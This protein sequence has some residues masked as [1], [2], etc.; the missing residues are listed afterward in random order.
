ML[1]YPSM[2]DQL[3][4]FAAG[5]PFAVDIHTIA[6][7]RCF[8]RLHY[9]KS[10]QQ[11]IQKRLHSASHH[12]SNPTEHCLSADDNP[13]Q[14]VSC[15]VLSGEIMQVYYYPRSPKATAE[16]SVRQN[17]GSLGAHLRR[18]GES[19]AEDLSA[20]TANSSS[21]L[22]IKAAETVTVTS[23]AVVTATSSSQ[24]VSLG[25]PVAFSIAT[26]PKTELAA[27]A[28][29]ADVNISTISLETADST[30]RSSSLRTHTRAT[31]QTVF[32]SFPSPSWSSAA[33]STSGYQP[34]PDT[35]SYYHCGYAQAQFVFNGCCRIDPCRLNGYCPRWA[36]AVAAGEPNTYKAL[37]INGEYTGERTQAV[38][39]SYHVIPGST[40]VA[41]MFTIN[42]PFPATASPYTETR[43]TA[44]TATAGTT[45][46]TA[47]A[48]K[49]GLSGGVAAGI[50]VGVIAG[51]L[52]LVGAGLLWWWR[53][54]RA[55]K[56]KAV[57]T[58]AAS[59]SQFDPGPVD[60]SMAN[61]QYRAYNALPQG[62]LFPYTQSYDQTA[63][64]PMGPGFENGP[65][66][67]YSYQPATELP[68][69]SIVAPVELPGNRIEVPAT[70]AKSGA[71]STGATTADG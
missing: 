17:V 40:T 49:T 30:T 1:L 53:R 4:D 21:T 36:Y 25:P 24:E 63:K 39:T 57:G 38:M 66:Y 19:I 61:V 6:I 67:E 13:D 52:A 10:L 18:K 22:V 42:G 50:I 62:G 12:A 31:S 60:P 54:R 9:L 68:G 41:D 47:A 44:A 64:S 16:P 26:V 70:P 23:S 71:A 29:L 65:R 69:N 14:P 20:M 56:A 3:L 51:V 11:S 15:V 33:H 27:K 2:K 59:R 28:M 8:A 43:V 46:T 34:C 5:P 55:R 48:E 37:T 32:T 7:E 35:Y 58:L 45:A